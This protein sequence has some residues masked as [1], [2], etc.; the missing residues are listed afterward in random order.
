MILVSSTIEAI[1]PTILNIITAFSFWYAMKD[2]TWRLVR[3]RPLTDTEDIPTFTL[4]PT[5]SPRIRR[6]DRL[7]WFVIL[8]SPSIE[9]INPTMLIPTFTLLSTFSPTIRRSDRLC[10]LVILVSPSIKA[11]NPI[12]LIPTFI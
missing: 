7:C 12:M 2:E 11:I 8:V 10:W 6:S 5:F 3:L 9:A 4:L 1:N